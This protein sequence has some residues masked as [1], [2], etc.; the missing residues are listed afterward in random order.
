MNTKKIIK[1]IAVALLAY[2]TSSCSDFLEKEVD[3]TLSEE[4]VFRSYENTLSQYLHL[5]TRRFCWLHRWTIPKRI[6][7]LHDR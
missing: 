4:Q 3:L 6:P 7:R 5:F 2:G 1:Y